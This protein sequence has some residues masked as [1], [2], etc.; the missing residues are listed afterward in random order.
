VTAVRSLP[1]GGL[2]DR[3][4]GGSCHAPPDLA[5]RSISNA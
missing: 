2:I 3:P 4:N 5:P 1:Y